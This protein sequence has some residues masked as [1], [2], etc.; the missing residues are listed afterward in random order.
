MKHLHSWPW[1]LR[2]ALSALPAGWGAQAA[3]AADPK[4][5]EQQPQQQQQQPAVAKAA[6]EKY[7]Q[8]QSAGL[9][10]K[11]SVT[12]AEPGLRALPA[13][14]TL[15]PFMPAGAAPPGRVSVGGRGHRGE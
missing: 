12:L 14:D 15:E 10:G 8:A 9:P 2:L 7:I 1:V 4:P 6:I 11:V 3:F 5:P 13:C